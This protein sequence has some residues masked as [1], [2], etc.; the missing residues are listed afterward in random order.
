VLEITFLGHQGWSFRTERSHVL[1]DP[2]LEETFGIGNVPLAVWPP[3]ILRLDAMP[4]VDAVVLT[5]EHE[6]HFH[7]PSLA[8][9]DRGTRIHL[10]ARS[11]T[12]AREIVKEMGFSLELLRPGEETTI[13]DLRVLPLSP[14]HVATVHDDEWDT[15]AVLVRDA[16]GH[17][18]FFSTVD[19]TLTARMLGAVM[20]RTAPIPVV[21]FTNNTQT[22]APLQ[23][24]AEPPPRMEEGLAEDMLRQQKILSAALGPCRLTVVCGGGFHYPGPLEWLDR[25]AFPADSERACA[26]VEVRAAGAFRAAHAGL[27]IRLRGGEIAGTE[28]TSPFVETVPRD[29]WPVRDYDPSSAVPAAFDPLT[30]R[31][32]LSPDERQELEGHLLELAAFLYGRSLFRALLSLTGPTSKK[33]SFVVAARDDRREL[34]YAYDPPACGFAP[35]DQATGDDFVA[36]LSAWGTDLLALLRGEISLT[37]LAAT[38]REWSAAVPV[39]SLFPDLWLFAHPLRRPDVML[40]AYRRMVAASSTAPPG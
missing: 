20:A 16:G 24:W 3:R 8:R 17:G 2:L 18:S 4:K 26:L 5:H 11:S 7:P 25:H 1:L 9:L 15:L 21:T 10:S 39:L 6:D 33:A 38:A 32:E 23:G 13:G 37:A 40:R 28:D 12:A 27:T 29:L 22:R 19:V 36:G 34:L 14:D 35:V 31:R 30:G